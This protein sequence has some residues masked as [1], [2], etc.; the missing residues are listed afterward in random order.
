M[1]DI[2]CR[3]FRGRIPRVVVKARFRLPELESLVH[4]FLICKMQITV[5]QGEDEV[6]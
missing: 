3:P 1:V 5:G 2:S 4:D 6:R